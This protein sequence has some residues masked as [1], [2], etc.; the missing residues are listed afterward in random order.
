MTVRIDNM[1]T[2]YTLV[3]PGVIPNDTDAVLEWLFRQLN[4]VDGTEMLS[5]FNLPGASLSVGARV[6]FTDI[7]KTQTFTCQSFGWEAT[8]ESQIIIY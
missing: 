3:I 8:S 4:A 7:T 5:V 1:G 2:E 6:T